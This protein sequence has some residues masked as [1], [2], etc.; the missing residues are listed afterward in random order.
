MAERPLR[1]LGVSTSV[2]PSGAERVLLRCARY[3][4]DTG[5]GRWTIASPPG[6][7]AEA[8]RAD[9]IDHVE[10]PETKLGG[11]PLPLAGTRLAVNTVRAGLR[12]RRL[13]ADYDVVVV[14][15]VMSLPAIRIGLPSRSR[16]V[17]LVHDVITRPG[18]RRIAKA[19][20]SAVD[21]AIGVSHASVHLAGRLGLATAVVHNGVHAPV[22]PTRARDG[23]P[24]VGINGMLT[25]WKGQK[26]FLEAMRLVDAPFEI[27]LLGGTFPKDGDYERLLRS[28]AGEPPLAG[29][30][31]LLGHVDDPIEAMRRWSIAVSASI[32]P[33]A[34]PLA[35][36]EAMSIGL[37]VVV[38]NHGGA[39]EIAGD[40]ALRVEPG[41][42]PAMAAA[43]EELLRCP[44]ERRRR[45]Q[46]GR[47]IVEERFT[48]EQA[49]ERFAAALRS[50]A[51][52]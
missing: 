47:A 39:V 17:W 23:A 44:D 40:V 20:A 4:R 41:D 34:G 48:L 12:L 15:S 14:N 21:L 51:A 8:V 22:P 45:G 5:A 13:A 28:M 38:T 10:L 43:V 25:S 7:F 3:G 46:R 52:S 42:V 32:E 27:E 30:V 18:L 49:N 19:S 50:V 16:V 33:E 2:F 36:L 9:G 6:A 31:Q 26:E 11:G 37:P 1:V 35:V 24:I 29:R